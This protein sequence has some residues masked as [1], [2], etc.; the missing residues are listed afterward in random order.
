M[1][2]VVK[3]AYGLDRRRPSNFQL[4]LEFIQK[5]KVAKRKGDRIAFKVYLEQAA[6]RLKN[7]LTELDNGQKALAELEREQ[8]KGH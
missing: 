4:L 1:N 6:G 7:C 5:A 2:N 3:T 8:H